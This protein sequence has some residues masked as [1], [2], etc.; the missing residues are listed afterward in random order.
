MKCPNCHVALEGVD[1]A[2][3]HIHRCPNCQGTWFDKDELR[4]LRDR[5]QKGGFHWL[6]V[7]L[8]RD[9]DKFRARQQ[10]GC[11]CPRDGRPMTTVRYGDSEVAIDVC[12]ACHGIWLDKG[13]YQRILDYLEETLDASSSADYLKDL[14]EEFVQALEGHE[15]PVEALRDVG[16]ILYLLEV[17]FTVEHPALSSLMT[18]FPRF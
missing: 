8:W 2:G 5:E 6:D 11:A 13:E 18:G 4:V 12:S 1:V 14:R 9:I 3:V 17:R 16:K 7:E 15:S 10:E